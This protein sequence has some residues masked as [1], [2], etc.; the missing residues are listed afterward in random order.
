M[1]N[2]RKRS[3]ASWCAFSLLLLFLLLLPCTR[4]MAQSEPQTPPCAPTSTPTSAPEPSIQDEKQSLKEPLS[5]LKAE[6]LSLKARHETLKTDLLNIGGALSGAIE[7]SE[8]ESASVSTAL[9][10]SATASTAVSSSLTSVSQSTNSLS[11]AHTDEVNA[12]AQVQEDLQSSV[13]KWQC[14]AWPAIGVAGAEAIVIV[15]L[16][17][18]GVI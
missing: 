11:Q 15:V 5:R 10:Q 3:E 12:S 16:L 6:L 7:L 9:A 18:K 4:A 2:G 13:R 1:R 8:S 17:V 14:I